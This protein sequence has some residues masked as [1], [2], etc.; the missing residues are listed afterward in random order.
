MNNRG[1]WCALAIALSS[2]ASQAT[3]FGNILALGDSITGG[4]AGSAPNSYRG[5]LDHLLHSNS[6]SY[7]WQGPNHWGFFASGKRNWNAGMGGWDMEMILEGNPGSPG[8][9]KLSDWLTAGNPD[10]LLFMTPINGLWRWQSTY[11][12]SQSTRD[13]AMAWNDVRLRHALDLSLAENP[14]LKI[15][16]ASPTKIGQAHSI[17]HISNVY[18]ADLTT[19]VKGIVLDYQLAGK[20]IEYVGI[21]EIITTDGSMQNADA[22]HWNALAADLGAQAFYTAMTTEAV[23]EPGTIAILTISSLLALRRRRSAFSTQ[24]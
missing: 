9:G 14:H 17:A 11:L 24:T 16:F 2:A 3:D 23:P 7:E 20:A 10:T 1:H 6:H 21:N 8:A 15:F 12:T 5:P 22:V 18:N 13:E 4:T 19:L